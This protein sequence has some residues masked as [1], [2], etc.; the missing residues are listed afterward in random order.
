VSRPLEYGTADRLQGAGGAYAEPLLHS[1]VTARLPRKHPLARSRVCCDRCR[2]IVH[3]PSNSCM[4]TW[5][6]TG[7]GNF[8]LRCF[9]LA[10]GGGTPEHRSQLAGV[11]CLPPSFGIQRGR[12]RR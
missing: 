8:C 7:N 9:T 12:T 3:L 4:R 5:V 1:H 10:A 2:S 6:E 11:D